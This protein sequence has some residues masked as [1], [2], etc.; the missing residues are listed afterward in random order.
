[1]S[2]TARVT[3]IDVLPLLAAALQK[4]RCEGAGAVDDVDSEVHRALE[5]IHHDRKDYWTHE[6]RRAE[7]ALNLARV[8]LQQA[9]TM[10]RIADSSPACIDEKRA[11]ERAK[12][13]VETARR[14]LEAVRHWSVTLDRAADD[15][16]KSHTQFDSWI[17]V[18]VSRAVAALNKMSESLVTY[19]TMK[20][21]D[22]P[23]P[24]KETPAA[25]EADKPAEAAAATGGA[26]IPVGQEGRPE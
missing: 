21:S 17:E 23:P 13:R 8:Q 20:A 19:I 26:D 16:R 24:E 2:R 6:L 5:W 22:E 9:M 10:R 4:F 3:S 11:L 7:E 25:A 12:R 18:D 14:K 15:F 1:M